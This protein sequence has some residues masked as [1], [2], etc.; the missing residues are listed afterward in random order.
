MLRDFG[1]YDP[2][3]GNMFYSAELDVKLSPL[4]GQ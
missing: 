2:V 4:L 3:C 1:L